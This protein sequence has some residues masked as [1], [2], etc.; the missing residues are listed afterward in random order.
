VA[1]GRVQGVFFRESTRRLAEERGVSGFV[2]NLPDGTLEAVF[3]G[4]EDAVAD[5]LA[6]A[7]SGP[8]DARVDRL[9]VEPGEPIG[10]S[11]FDVG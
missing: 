8:Q 10:L 6:F 1:H 2:R 3:E 9:D 7:A 4:P 5:L 11:G